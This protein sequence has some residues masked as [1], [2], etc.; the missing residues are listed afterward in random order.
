MEI[1]TSWM[2]KGIEQGAKREAVA[3]ALRL[4]HRRLGEIPPESEVRVQELSTEQAEALCEAVLD[5]QTQDDLVN[6]LNQN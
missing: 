5:F 3:L 1:V 4:L 2:E 6:W